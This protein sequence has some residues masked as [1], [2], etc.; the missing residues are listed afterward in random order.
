MAWALHVDKVEPDGSILVTHT[1][2]GETQG[3]C[4]ELRDK[5]GAGCQAF[6]PALTAG[7]I[8]EEWE[9]ID[10]IPCVDEDEEEEVDG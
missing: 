4:E 10:E 2:Y 9:E 6:G 7:K 8:A 3:E 5:H 1:F